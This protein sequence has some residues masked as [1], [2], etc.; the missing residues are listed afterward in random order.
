[1]RIEFDRIV[2]G[3]DARN[4]AEGLFKRENDIAFYPCFGIE[5]KRFA[6]VIFCFFAVGFKNPHTRFRF[7]NTGY[8]RFPAFRT[9]HF[10]KSIEIFVD[11]RNEFAQDRHAFKKDNVPPF[12]FSQLCSV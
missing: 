8:Q 4:H 2:E 9:D 6:S 12:L 7:V 1:M 11:Q 10:G 3:Y 5:G